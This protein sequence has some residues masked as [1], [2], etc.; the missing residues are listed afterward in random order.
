MTVANVTATY[1][2]ELVEVN[3]DIRSGSFATLLDRGDEI[4][5][6]E[7]YEEGYFEDM[8]GRYPEAWDEKVRFE[9][10][11]EQADGGDTGDEADVSMT[12]LHVHCDND[13]TM[14]AHC[15]T[16]QERPYCDEHGGGRKAGHARVEEWV[17][18]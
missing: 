4:V 5:V 3:D 6:H 14:V 12:C 18:L 17:E 11:E 1:D 13:P 2:G 10:A 7:V 8:K 9:D 16:G 15:D